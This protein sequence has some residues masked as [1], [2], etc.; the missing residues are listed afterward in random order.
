MC[1]HFFNRWH[2][3]CKQAQFI[4]NLWGSISSLPCA[5][6]TD[7]LYHFF[8]CSIFYY[9]DPWHYTFLPFFCTSQFFL[10]FLKYHFH[11]I[12]FLFSLSLL[13]DLHTPPFL[14]CNLCSSPQ[15]AS[16]SVYPLRAE[17]FVEEE[18]ISTNT[19]VSVN[20]CSVPV[21]VGGVGLR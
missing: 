5:N 11:I 10:I 6:E 9:S 17:E 18:V 2:A 20:L 21:K 7:P 14:F 1:V 8:F 15:L 12:T 19:G 4:A 13:K 3:L 16:S